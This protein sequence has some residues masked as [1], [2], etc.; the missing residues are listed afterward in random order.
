MVDMNINL[1]GA[2]EP[3][4]KNN[5][6][7]PN[8]LSGDNSSQQSGSIFDNNS[9]MPTVIS[10]LEKQN[11]KLDNAANKPAFEMT[12]A[13]KQDAQKLNKEQQ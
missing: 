9:K 13:E 6:K 11:K 1:S 5:N 10:E 4:K 2:N 12:K 8:Y 7:V 3:Q